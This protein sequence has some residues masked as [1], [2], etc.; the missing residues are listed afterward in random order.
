MEEPGHP[1]WH[2]RDVLAILTEDAKPSEAEDNVRHSL[3]IDDEAMNDNINTHNKNSQ[4]YFRGT[5][6]AK[7]GT[8][9]PVMQ[10]RHFDEW[11]EEQ[12]D[13]HPKGI[14]WGKSNPYL[15]G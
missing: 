1:C 11:M 5:R 3:I 2:C 6:K 9:K 8:T 12:A 13:E 10:A 4:D 7:A 15:R 14:M